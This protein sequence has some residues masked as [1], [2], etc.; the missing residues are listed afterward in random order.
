[1]NY[2]LTIN[3]LHGFGNINYLNMRNI[4]KGRCGKELA[5]LFPH[6]VGYGVLP[7]KRVHE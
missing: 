3:R 5:H 2:G 7:W 1:M 4:I 6:V